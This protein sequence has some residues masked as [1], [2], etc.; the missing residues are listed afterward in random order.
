M[1]IS[2]ITNRINFA[3]NNGKEDRFQLLVIV[4]ATV[5]DMNVDANDINVITSRW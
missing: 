5:E 1:T 3:K 4:R 2:E